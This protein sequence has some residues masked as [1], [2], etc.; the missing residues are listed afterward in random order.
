MAKRRS[1]SEQ[2]QRNGDRLLEAARRVFLAKGYA[3]ASL[4]AIAEA[5]GFS[6]GVVYSQFDSKGDLFLTLLERRIEDRAV[7]NAE[8]VARTSGRR[9]VIALLDLAQRLFQE[10]PGWSMLVIEFRV[11]AARDPVLRERYAKAHARTVERFGE[12]LAMLHERDGL[13][14]AFP[15]RTM[16]ELILALGAGI[17]LERINDPKALPA[18]V[19]SKMIPAAIG[20]DAAAGKEKR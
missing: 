1:R 5:A 8:I 6:K 15:V 19:M 7:L 20:L 10:E 2:V 3:Y 18:S 17:H 12:A 14:P 11:H 9:G 16:A 4:D 13:E